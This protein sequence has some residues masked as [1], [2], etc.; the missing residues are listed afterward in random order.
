MVD[1]TQIDDEKKQRWWG[2]ERNR[3]RRERYR[4][5]PEYRKQVRQQTRQS[6]QHS[7]AK[8]GRQV[9]A[10]NCAAN[11]ANLG[12]FGTV[13]DVVYEEGQYKEHLTFTVEEI[14]K[15]LNRNRQV[16]YRWTSTD[17][18]PRPTA[19]AVTD[20]NHNQPVYVEQ[21]VI[22]AVKAFSA[23]QTI[24]Q[25]YHQRHVETRDKI[26]AAMYSARA[27]YAAKGMCI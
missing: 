17:M 16:I 18:F 8:E 24:S 14:A 23:H 27:D 2:E 15:V 22:G 11:L 13:R 5:D 19:R 26:Y 10:D 12:S 6:Y 4:S 1:S 7:R 25:Y 9:R 21:E 3:R 20:H